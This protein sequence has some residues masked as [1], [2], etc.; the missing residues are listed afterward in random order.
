MMQIRDQ[1]IKTALIGDWNT[2]IELNKL[3]LE[4]NPSDVDAMNRLAFAFK[5]L[6]KIEQ[7]KAIYKQVLTMDAFNPIALKNLKRLDGINGTQR[8]NT[9]TVLAS[10]FI[11]EIGKTRIVELINNATADIIVALR[12][13]ESV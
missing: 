9:N 2:A 5:E 4:H 3:L 11:E 12:V 10:A 13:G 7:A 6:G 1:A 8:S